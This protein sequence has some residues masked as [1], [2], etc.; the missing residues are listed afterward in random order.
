MLPSILFSSL[1]IL[2]V[3]PIQEVSSHGYML[4]PI[5][6]N[7]AAHIYGAGSSS[8]RDDVPIK[9]WSYPG[10]ENGGE[11]FGACGAI[12][13]GRDIRFTSPS[14]WVAPDG[15]SLPFQA[16]EIYNEGDVIDVYS[17]IRANH[18]GHIEVRAFIPLCDTYTYHI[19]MLTTIIFSISFRCMH[20]PTSPTQQMI[21][22]ETI[23]LSLL[24]IH[25]TEPRK[26]QI[27]IM[28]TEPILLLA[29]VSEMEHTICPSPV[30]WL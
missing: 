16:Y 8:N 22:S 19:T 10:L 3:S 2:L 25:F 30:Y 21:A 26:I 5:S 14:D 12:G 11:T 9:T 24:K 6:R 17:I 27:A 28:L 20:A 15:T 13:L 29:A 1:L 23:H 18:R 4:K 7:W